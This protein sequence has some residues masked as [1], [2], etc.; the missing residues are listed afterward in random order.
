MQCTPNDYNGCL[1]IISH[2]GTFTGKPWM[3]G[4]LIWVG[5]SLLFGLAVYFIERPLIEKRVHD[6]HK[7]RAEWIETA[8]MYFG[9]VMNLSLFLYVFVIQYFAHRQYHKVYFMDPNPYWFSPWGFALVFLVSNLIMFGLI[10]WGQKERRKPMDSTSVGMGFGFIVLSG[11]ILLG[12][13]FVMKPGVT[14]NPKEQHYLQD[15]YQTFQQYETRLRHENQLKLAEAKEQQAES[16]KVLQELNQTSNLPIPERIRQLQQLEKENPSLIPPM[17][18][19]EF[20]RSSSR[21]ISR[22]GGQSRSGSRSTEYSPL[23]S[24]KSRDN[25]ISLEPLENANII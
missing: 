24:T 9:V 20:S 13:L 15:A 17:S 2:Q 8:A 19:R 23:A 7:R 22:N 11:L 14:L 18:S 6:P 5:L 10:V 21:S 16:E 25:N 4:L 12:A 3:W 1:D